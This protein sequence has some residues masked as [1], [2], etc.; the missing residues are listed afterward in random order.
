VNKNKNKNKK[1]P[2]FLG[3]QK[4]AQVRG[5]RVAF[6][7]GPFFNFLNGQTPHNAL[8][9]KKNSGQRVACIA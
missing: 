5:P 6:V 8:K 4:K 1:G 9:K 7:L 2:E 3:L